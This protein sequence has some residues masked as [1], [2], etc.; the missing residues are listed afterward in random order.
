MFESYRLTS[1]EAYDLDPTYHVSAPHLAFN[2]LLRYIKRPIEL[3][4]DAGMYQMIHPAVRGGICHASVRF[5][6]AN[7]KYMGSR[8]KPEEESSFIFYID[9]TN[10][11]KDAMSQDLP[12][13]GYEFLSEEECRAAETALSGSPEARDAFFHVDREKHGPYY[14]L[15]V[16]LEYAPEIHDRDDDFPMAP[17]LMD[18]TP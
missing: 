9:K 12:E 8:Y 13:G 15:T 10:H 5:V 14:I 17:E 18:I 3:I 4:S 1:K 2:A 7:N 11:Y 16:D 6:R